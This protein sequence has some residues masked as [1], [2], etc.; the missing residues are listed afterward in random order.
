[1]IDRVEVARLDDAVQVRV[2]E[3]QPG[4]RAPVAEQ[5]RL[6]VLEPQRLAQQ[7]VVEQ[8]DLADRQVVRRPPVG[9]DQVELLYR[10]G[11][12]R[13]H[14]VTV[15]ACV[16]CGA[17]NQPGSCELGCGAEERLDLVPAEEHD[18]LVAWVQASHARAEG[19]RV[20]VGRLTA[21]PADAEC[22]YRALQAAAR[23]AL[24]E[25][26]APPAA[27]A[28]ARVSTTWWCPRCGGVDAPQ[29]CLGICVWR[30]FEWVAAEDYERARSQL[31]AALAE[32]RGLRELLRRA[33]TITPRA[34][35]WEHG[36]AA[37]ATAVVPPDA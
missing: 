20:A 18:E 19:L 27:P 31:R 28:P 15:A 16:G 26:P 2:D 1:M 37:L 32:E 7:R 24:S 17:M 12:H 9:V 4:R 34:G 3:V 23:T 30:P 25:Q 10:Q 5:P 6:D 8:V 33:A 29:P 35:W 36:W 22:A 21:H 13:P 11:V 14:R